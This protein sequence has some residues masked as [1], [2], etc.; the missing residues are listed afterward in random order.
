MENFFDLATPEE[1]TGHISG[2]DTPLSAEEIV[3]EALMIAG[4]ICIYTN[5]DIVVETV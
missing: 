1:I 2:D 3:R 5:G 4:D